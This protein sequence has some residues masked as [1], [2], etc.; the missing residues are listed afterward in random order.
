MEYKVG[1][2]Y[3]GFENLPVPT[4]RGQPIG[5]MDAIDPL[6]GK[7]KWR[8]PVMDIPNYSAMLATAGGLLFTGKQTGEFIALDMDTGKI[9]WQFQTGSGIN[10][11]PITYT[12]NGRQYVTIQVGLGGVNARAWRR[13]SPTCRAAARCGRSRSWIEVVSGNTLIFDGR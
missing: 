1:Q 4:G 11:Q 8:T 5:H 10:A 6:T 3:Q 13:S 12:H 2:R 7:Q 9:L